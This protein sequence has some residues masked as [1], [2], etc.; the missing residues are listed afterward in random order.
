MQKNTEKILQNCRKQGCLQMQ[1][2]Q[3]NDLVECRNFIKKTCRNVDLEAIVDVDFSYFYL[4]IKIFSVDDFSITLESKNLLFNPQHGL[5]D[6]KM[7]IKVENN[8][9]VLNILKNINI[10]QLQIFPFYVVDVEF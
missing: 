6:H 7:H 9:Y 8:K 5:W 2:F 3:G 1:N 10:F 4:Q